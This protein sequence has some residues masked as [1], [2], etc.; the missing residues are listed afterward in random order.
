MLP[1]VVFCQFFHTYNSTSDDYSV[2]DAASQVSD[3]SHTSWQNWAPH[4][5]EELTPVKPTVTDGTSQCGPVCTMSQRMAESVSQW[6]FYRDQGMH[7][8]ASQATMG[9]A[10]EDLFHDAHLQLQEQMRNP[11]T[12]H[13]EIMGDIIYL[14]QVLKQPD[15]KEF[16]Q[17]FIKK[18]NGHVDSNN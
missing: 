14:Q 8:M 15:A 18:V 3:N 13:A 5:I 12:F 1:G 2:S 7:Y 11:I 17:A 6:C 9:N 4:I 16:V 10:D